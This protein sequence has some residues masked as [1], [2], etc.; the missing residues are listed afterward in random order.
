MTWMIWLMVGI[1]FIGLIGWCCVAKVGNSDYN[2]LLSWFFLLFAVASGVILGVLMRIDGNYKSDHTIH[3]SY[4]LIALLLFYFLG[5]FG[6]RVLTKK[7]ED[8]K[9]VVV[10][11]TLGCFNYLAVS[12][13]TTAL[14]TWF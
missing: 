10:G 6:F 3:W 4:I 11:C 14:I 9:I 5:G 1:F 8:G 12:F 7:A 13:C 2:P